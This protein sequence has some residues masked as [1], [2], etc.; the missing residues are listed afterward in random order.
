LV[1]MWDGDTSLNDT[2]TKEGY[3]IPYFI[4][5]N[6]VSPRESGGFQYDTLFAMREAALDARKGKKGNW[7]LI[8]STLLPMELRFLTMREF[9]SRYC[10]I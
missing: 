3:A 9:P 5:P 8:G 6:A 7:P 4:Y 2:L 1:Y 10:A